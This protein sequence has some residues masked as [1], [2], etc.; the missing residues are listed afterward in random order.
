MKN[1]GLPNGIWRYKTWSKEAYIV[2][3]GDKAIDEN[4]YDRRNVLWY[5][6]ISGMK[7][8]TRISVKHYYLCLLK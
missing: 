7:G 5:S 4:G 8:W 2:C 6:A 3:I 1:C